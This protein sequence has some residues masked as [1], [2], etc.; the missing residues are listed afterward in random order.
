MGTSIDLNA[1][2][3]L[4]SKQACFS[5]LSDEETHVLANLLVEQTIPAGTTIVTEGDPVDS[6]FL[7][8]SGTADVKVIVRHDNSSEVKSVATLGAGDA[9]G[10]N[11]TGFYLLT[12]A[13][14][15]T[16]VAITEMVLLQLSIPRFHGFALAYSHVSEIMRKQ[17]AQM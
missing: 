3:D 1:R 16:V 9:I 8:V 5:Q 7:I 14:T 12:G 2:I 10:L 6:F 17:A 13:R 15:A 4:V 11:E